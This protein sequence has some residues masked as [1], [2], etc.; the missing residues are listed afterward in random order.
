M[1]D[2]NKPISF[3][4]IFCAIRLN[5]FN[6]FKNLIENSPNKW[7]RAQKHGF[8]IIQHILQRNRKEMFLY[9]LNFQDMMDLEKVLIYILTHNNDNENDYYACEII[10]KGVFLHGRY[11]GGRNFL[12]WS[13]EKNWINMTRLLL[14]K[15]MSVNIV[16]K[17]G[18]TV[19]QKVIER[20]RSSNDYEYIVM[21]LFYGANVCLRNSDGY[22]AFELAVTQNHS[23]SVQESLFYRTL[24]E[25]ARG[26][27]HF[28]VLF[29]L[30]K[31]GSPFSAKYFSIMLRS[32]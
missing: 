13:V 29:K 7:L 3:L 18:H 31:S 26:K 2:N 27:T 20:G 8:D 28:K 6:K 30:I 5:D 1:T 4:D 10:K 17:N 9:L 24:D 32:A 16:D 25:R 15:G 12:H 11:I 21:L 23:K 14:D 19:L 22:N